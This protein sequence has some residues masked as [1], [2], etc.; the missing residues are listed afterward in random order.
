MVDPTRLRSSFDQVA[1]YG[2]EVP[3]FFYSSLF[4]RHPET[5]R[6]FPPSMAAQRDRLVGALGTIVSDVDNLDAL[7][8]FVQELG[9]DHR[10]F[11][12]DADH[13]PAVGE[14]LL[15][16]LAHFLG[17]QW[18]DDL[19]A[20]W[21][22][23]F[24]VVAAVMQEAAAGVAADEPPWWDA[25]IVAHDRRCADLAVI[26]VR[27]SGGPDYLPGQS[28]SVQT[29]LRPR[30]W[31]Y[32]SP[33]NAARR[34]GLI[35][36]HVRAVDGGW[37]SSAL[38]HSAGQGDTLMLG[39]AVGELVLDP[40]SDRD[41]L[42]VASGSGLA[43]LRAMIDHATRDAGWSRRVHLFVGGRRGHDLYD[44]PALHRVE[45]AHQWL[46]VVPVVEIGP[47]PGCAVGTP[48]EVALSCGR[49]NEH[50]VY[51]CGSDPMVAYSRDLLARS[52]LDAGRLRHESFGYRGAHS[53]A[54]PRGAPALEPD[55]GPAAA[56]STLSEPDRL[57]PDRPGSDRPGS[58]RP[59][60]D[61]LEPDRLGTG[62]PR[63]AP[64]RGV[65]VNGGEQ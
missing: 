38:V 26:T 64:P 54:A 11:G 42:L 34:D 4:L 20:E 53:G 19:A 25:E 16:T 28:L 48:A 3:L 45:A 37:V 60:P 61:H 31:R 43:P 49:W 24:G 41:L 55:Q 14:A 51:V 57:E 36:F 47:V 15:A 22:E 52:G 46:T 5:R 23:A 59:A 29:P 1:R 2:D 10:K 30:L 63:P 8:P 56:P 62:Q 21:G 27:T 65:L 33:A 35:E 13:Y 44:L 58:D 18:T 40:E 7:I 32:F 9:R 50:D 12:V 17:D 39:P 6:M